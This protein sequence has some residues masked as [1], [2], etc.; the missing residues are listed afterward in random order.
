MLPDVSP[1]RPEQRAIGLDAIEL[2][3]AER[4]RFLGAAC[5]G[6]GVLERRGREPL[7]A[8]EGDG[9]ALDLAGVCRKLGR[10]K[11]AVPLLERAL[12]IG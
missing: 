4:E 12:T 6:V 5:G 8:H 7:Q 9:R 11:G 2:P 10:T 3:A 1:S